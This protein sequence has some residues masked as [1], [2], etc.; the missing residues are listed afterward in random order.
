M[1][2]GEDLLGDA[3]AARDA[4]LL[5]VLLLWCGRALGRCLVLRTTHLQCVTHSHT[6]DAKQEPWK[7][8]GLK[9]KKQQ[10]QRQQREDYERCIRRD[11]R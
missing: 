4:V 5:G 1:A 3:A 7:K 2:N 10:Q 8:R 11:K 6:H 9:K